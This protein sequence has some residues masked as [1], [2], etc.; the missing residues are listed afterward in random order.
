MSLGAEKWV[1]F[2]ESKNLVADVKAATGDAGPH[3][4]LV[5]AGA[6]GRCVIRYPNHHANIE[7]LSPKSLGRL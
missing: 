1:D 2:R 7:L 6:V 3:V 5:A 4:A